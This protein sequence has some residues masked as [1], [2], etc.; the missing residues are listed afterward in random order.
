M[1]YLSQE[2]LECN[3]LICNSLKSYHRQLSRETKYLALPVHQSV[4]LSMVI[5]LKLEKWS[6]ALSLVNVV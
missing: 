4:H 2:I 6:L 3:E 1:I 5:A